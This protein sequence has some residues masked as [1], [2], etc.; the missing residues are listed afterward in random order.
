MILKMLDVGCGH[1]P[2]GDANVDLFL[3]SN[4]HRIGDLRDIPNLICADCH[5]LPFRD[6]SFNV[7]YC[8]HLLEHKGV[9]LSDICREL[10]R[11]AGR[12]A[13]IYVPNMFR[14]S[15]YSVA[16]GKIF[17]RDAFNMIFRHFERKV[18]YCGYDWKQLYLPNRWLRSLCNRDRIKGKIRNPLHLLPCPIPTEIKVEVNKT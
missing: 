5:H 13:L 9:N 1:N 14:K 15:K 16:H 18:S 8:H 12:K 7:V 6:S 2:E 4:I 17:S 3:R 11:V 10:L